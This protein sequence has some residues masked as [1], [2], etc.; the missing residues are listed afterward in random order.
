M[1]RRI[2]V[3]ARAMNLDPM[4]LRAG[5]LDARQES[6]RGLHLSGGGTHPS[7][8]DEPEGKEAAE[9][10]FCPPIAGL[11]SEPDPGAHRRRSGPSVA[12]DALRPPE[13]A[14]G[15]DRRRG[16]ALEGGGLDRSPGQGQRL[17]RPALDERV[18]LFRQRQ[19]GIRSR[20]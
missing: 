20:A 15:L 14:V 16:V 1:E 19:S 13:R 18:C 10:P 5:Q 11:H 7:V 6:E 8:D 4:D 17:A 3:A 2:H 12:E 9:D